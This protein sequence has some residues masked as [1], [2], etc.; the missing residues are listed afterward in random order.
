MEN[1]EFIKVEENKDLSR[2]VYSG[3]IVNTN[4]SAYEKAIARSRAAKVQRDELKNATKEINNLQD[5][6]REIKI[7]LQQLVNK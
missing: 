3:G 7:L 1:K 4:R 5:E 2:D 6:M